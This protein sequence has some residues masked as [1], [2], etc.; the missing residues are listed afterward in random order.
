MNA[1]FVRYLVN[2]TQTPQ[3]RREK[4]NLVRRAGFNCYIAQRLRDWQIPDIVKY[5]EEHVRSKC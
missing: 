3:E 1:E 2:A 5:I 4:Y